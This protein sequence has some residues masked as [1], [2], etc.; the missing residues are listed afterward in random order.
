[1][2][3]RKD[4]EPPIPREEPE[5]PTS[6][7]HR[8]PP[9]PTKSRIMAAQKML[10]PPRRATIE[11]ELDWLEFVDE[12]PTTLARDRSSAPPKGPAKSKGHQR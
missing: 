3:D 7:K 12:E 4:R 8:A 1:M 10:P 6:P 2:A 11:V 5:A 9:K